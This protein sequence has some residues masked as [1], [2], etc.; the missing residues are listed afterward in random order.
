MSEFTSSE[1][2]RLLSKIDKMY[3]KLDNLC[4][5][6]I[7]V[8]VSLENHLESQ[9]TKFNRTTVILSIVIAGIAVVVGVMASLK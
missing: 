9:R 1:K 4:G 2:E 5:R 8:E 7:K 6:M 3:S